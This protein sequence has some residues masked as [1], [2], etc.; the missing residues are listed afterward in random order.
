[1]TTLTATRHGS[2]TAPHRL[3][4]VLLFTIAATNS[5]DVNPKTTKSRPY[6]NEPFD[7]FRALDR[8]LSKLD[9]QLKAAGSLLDRARTGA[10]ATTSGRRARSPWSDGARSIDKTLRSMLL[11][12]DSLHR[13]YAQTRSGFA[14]SL[15]APLPGEVKKMRNDTRALAKASTPADAKRALEAVNASR[16]EF[17]LAFQAISG[18]YAG[19]RCA[20]G[21]WSCCSPKPGGDQRGCT[22]SCVEKPR[23]CTSGFVGPR[24]RS[25]LE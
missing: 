2:F 19:L 20:R 12:V 18:G 8:Q 24:S 1:M 17:V 6:S 22:W 9:A 21:Q 4:L 5:F 14:K 7:S 16:L 13:R 10:I 25:Q 3:L 23:M 11:T 15:L